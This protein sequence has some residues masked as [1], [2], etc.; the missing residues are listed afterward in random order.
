MSAD[1]DE[2]KRATD[3]VNQGMASLFKLYQEGGL[4]PLFH[5]ALDLLENL[6]GEAAEVQRARAQNGLAYS[7]LLD[8]KQARLADMEASLFRARLKDVERAFGVVAAS[9]PDEHYRVYP[10]GNQGY[11]RA[12][13]GDVKGAKEILGPLYKVKG[14]AGREGTLIDTRLLTVSEDG[15]VALLV[16]EAWNE[17]SGRG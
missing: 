7:S 10:L 4:A 17:V 12:L 2:L 1:D 14:E 5:N 15:A 8:L 9:Q 11:V 13:M 6:S 16:E 3:L